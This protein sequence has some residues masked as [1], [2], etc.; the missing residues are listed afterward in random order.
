MQLVDK[1]NIFFLQHSS[2]PL[3]PCGTFSAHNAS[4]KQQRPGEKT[5]SLMERSLKVHTVSTKRELKG[6]RVNYVI[7][8]H[9]ILTRQS[10]L[11]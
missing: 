7:R 10:Y 5:T 11:V 4:L 8:Y 2:F 6:Y 3:F 9:F 1:R